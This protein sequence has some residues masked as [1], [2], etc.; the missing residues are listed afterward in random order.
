MKRIDRVTIQVSEEHYS[1]EKSQ[2]SAH[3]VEFEG[4]LRESFL[5]YP[6]AQV[7]RIL[8]LLLLEEEE[9]HLLLKRARPGRV[10]ERLLRGR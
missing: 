3:F 1:Q 5:D 8:L 2:F 7:V 6:A 9:V 4:R 10:A